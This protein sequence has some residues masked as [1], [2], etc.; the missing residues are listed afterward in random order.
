MI[1]SKN[2]T[3]ISPT[4]LHA[5]PASDLVKLIKDFP[6]DCFIINQDKRVNA[7]SM[8]SLLTLGAKYNTEVTVECNGEQHDIAC[9]TIIKFLED[10][11]D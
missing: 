2:V 3:I 1:T 8:I 4:G 10:M 6:C 9:D 11:K 5:R 7:K